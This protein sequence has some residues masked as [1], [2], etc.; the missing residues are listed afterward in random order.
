VLLPAGKWQAFLG[1]GL[2]AGLLL[3]FVSGRG[4]KVF[5][6]ENRI[7]AR[8]TFAYLLAWFATTT[9]T[10]GF[11]LLGLKDLVALGLT[12][13]VFSTAM[14]TAV[15]LVVLKKYLAE[16]GQHPSLAP[17]GRP[18][19]AVPA[20][21][22]IIALGASARAVDLTY[23]FSDQIQVYYFLVD[24]CFKSLT[25][26]GFEGGQVSAGGES[27]EGPSLVMSGSKDYS[28]KTASSYF[29]VAFSHFPNG[30]APPLPRYTGTN[31]PGEDPGPFRSIGLGEESSIQQNGHTPS[32]IEWDGLYYAD[33]RVSV[34]S[35]HW[36]MTVYFRIEDMQ[37]ARSAV[38]FSVETAK[39]A[40][41]QFLTC[42]AGYKAPTQVLPPPPKR[43][44]PSDPEAVTAMVITVL[45]LLSLLG[46]N[47]TTSLAEAL[48]AELS[49]AEEPPVAKPSRRRPAPAKPATSRPPDLR[50]LFD[51]ESGKDLVVQDGRY[52]GG[53]IGQVWYKDKWMDRAAAEAAIAMWEAEYQTDRRQWFDGHTSAWER[54][55]QEKIE[56]DN[57]EIDPYTGAWRRPL[58]SDAAEFV[59]PAEAGDASR[60][61]IDFGLTGVEISHKTTEDR[62]AQLAGL[63]GEAIERRDEAR[64]KYQDALESGDRWLADKLKQRLDL[65]QTHV[66]AV[67]NAADDLQRRVDLRTR[68]KAAF[69]AG[70]D[71]VSVLDV[72]RE[73]S[74]LPY[75]LVES[76]KDD[77]GFVDTMKIAI[78]TRNK[79]QDLMNEA[80]ELYGRHDSALDRLQ[81][82]KL[83]IDQAR[84]AGDKGLEASLRARAEPIK[85]ELRGIQD[86]LNLIHKTK[87]QWERRTSQANLA[88]Y[89]KAADMVA[90]GTQSAEMGATVNRAIDGYRRLSIPGKTTADSGWT[91]IDK[92]SLNEMELDAEHFRGVQKA[93]QKYDA[94][95]QA[96]EPPDLRKATLDMLEDYQAKIQMRSKYSHVQDRWAENVA[97]F[98]DKP[99]FNGLAEECN[100]RGWVT[101]DKGV[102]RPVTKDD[103]GK[104][105]SSRTGAPG[106]D[107]DVKY[108]NIIDPKTNKP[109]GFRELQDAAD[110]ACGR[111][112]FDPVKQEIKVVGGATGSAHPEALSI[113][114]GATAET[115][116]SPGHLGRYDGS[117]AEQAYRVTRVKADESLHLSQADRMAEACRTSVKD[118]ERV[119]RTLMETREGAVAKPP[120]SDKAIKI[121]N[122]VGTG[123]L[124]PGTGNRQFR[125]LTGMDLAQGCEKLDSLQETLVKLDPSGK[126]TSREI[127]AGTGMTLEEKV[128]RAE[129]FADGAYRGNAP[130][131]PDRDVP[132]AVG[133]P[134]ELLD[135]QK[136]PERLGTVKEGTLKVSGDGGEAWWPK[137]EDGIPFRSIAPEKWKL[138]GQYVTEEQRW[139]ARDREIGL[140]PAASAPVELGQILGT[141]RPPELEA[142]AAANPDFRRL[143]DTVRAAWQ[144]AGGGMDPDSWA[145]LQGALESRGVDERLFEV[146]QKGATE[147]VWS[148]K[149]GR[150]SGR[151]PPLR[152][153]G[154]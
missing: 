92:R 59:I 54:G 154:R 81:R 64:R 120:F 43:V 117:D 122:D 89:V 29:T 129:T 69:Q 21:L 19:P 152:R 26:P 41:S 66:D 99:L 40:W 51:P 124:P 84:S 141:K 78:A 77:A 150:R 3:G 7:F 37:L 144:E 83:E 118:Y 153:R 100:T 95:A 62:F 4:H 47:I 137:D 28:H 50:P 147:G 61:D 82:L 46:V 149:S 116:Y 90:T 58:E 32:D 130:A 18:G 12:G 85:A 53:R 134:E 63:K 143:D 114:P 55:V 22:L 128:R 105:T 111:L 132:G 39:L 16:K 113:K 72:G 88:A 15:S 10:Q 108:A 75:Q 94:W 119:S 107:L 80:P 31:P 14:V 36:W 126:P 1:P 27:G 79:L 93:T 106:N 131:L 136:W 34:R 102:L 23:R 6:K 2:A 44:V 17:P 76:L 101:N 5:I 148:P 127:L 151:G 38:E 139:I 98:R 146:W 86:D 35:G 71:N 52:Q 96:C 20:I 67:Q 133:W 74:R 45:L 48:Y 13:G 25:F 9:A 109:V 142:F 33:Y 112:G 104:V 125:E 57:M 123:A 97:E 115:M 135:G 60:D 49:E 140:R 87:Q 68:Q 138:E 8:R 65:A 121:M 30:P 42:L 103:F 110:K 73:L 24:H 56:R 70:I 91:V 145:S 11:A